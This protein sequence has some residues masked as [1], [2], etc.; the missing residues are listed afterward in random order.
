MRV[1]AVAK[2]RTRHVLGI[3]VG[4]TGVKAAVV[5]TTS[6]S[7]CSARERIATPKPATPSAVRETVQALHRRLE[8]RGPVGM[9]LPGVVTDG[10]MQTAANLDKSW[11]GVPLAELLAGVLPTGTTY[12]N[13][14]DAAGLAEARF[15][16]ARGVRG[17]VVMVTLGTGIGAALLH[18]GELVPNAEL[19]HIEMNGC[20]AE[21]TTSASARERIAMDWPSW[22]RQVSTYLQTIEGLLWPSLFVIGG[23]VTTD[24]SPWFP[25]LKARTPVRLAHLINNA[26]I[27][28]AAAATLATNVRSTAEPT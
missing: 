5:D 2:P 10:V 13:D 12:L 19:G 27:V 6:G 8:W 16:A 18:N 15:G 3:D 17:L 14:A 4:G 22:A 26:G 1:K 28:G 20:D 11:I 9:A 21:T 23:G 25:L 24:P 7:L